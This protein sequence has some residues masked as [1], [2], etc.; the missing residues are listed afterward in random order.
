MEFKFSA[1]VGRIFRGRESLTSLRNYDQTPGILDSKAAF[2]FVDNHDNQRGH[3]AGGEDILTFKQR[4]EYVMATAF[5]LAY[6]YGAK[7]IMSSYNFSNPSQ[8]IVLFFKFT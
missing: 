6:P 4:R 8:G 7:Q 3:G 1:D 2:V 5:N